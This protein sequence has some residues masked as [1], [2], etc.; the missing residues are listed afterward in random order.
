MKTVSFGMYQAFKLLGKG[1]PIINTTQKVDIKLLDLLKGG[2]VST[3]TTHPGFH[4]DSNILSEVWT[5]EHE[6]KKQNMKEDK[7]KRQCGSRL[8]QPNRRILSC[9]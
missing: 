7:A 8:R 3:S 5:E 2:L 4:C 6:G 9:C 1:L